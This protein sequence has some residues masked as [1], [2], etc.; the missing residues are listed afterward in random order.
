MRKIWDIFRT[1]AKYNFKHP[2]SFLLWIISKYLLLACTLVL[3]LLTSSYIDNLTYY[4][5]RDAFIRIVLLVLGAMLF[6][7]VTL[8]V[9]ECV[10]SP[11]KLKSGSLYI[12]DL[13]SRMQ[14]NS[15]KHL[16]SQNSAYFT[17]ILA[18]S[19]NSTMLFFYAMVFDMPKALVTLLVPIYVITTQEWR[20]SLALI[21]IVLLNFV[22]Y[23]LLQNPMYRANKRKMEKN[24]DYIASRNEQL[25]AAKFIK[26]NGLYQ[27]FASRLD[28]S[29]IGYVKAVKGER[30]VQALYSLS[31]YFVASGSKIAVYFFGGL[32]VLNGDLTV[33]T[34]LMLVEYV[35]M[36]L[37]SLEYFNELGS[38]YQQASVAYDKLAEIK[39][40]YA[41]KDG[42]RELANVNRVEFKNLC[43]DYGEK[44]IFKDFNL[45]LTKGKLYGLYGENGAGK[46]TLLNLLLGLYMGDYGGE[47][48]LDGIDIKDLN[49]T[50]CKQTLIGVTEQEPLLMK[51]TLYNNICLGREYD[52]DTIYQ[53]GKIIGLSSYFDKLPDG[54]D[55]EINDKSTN[56]SGGEKQKISILRQ[57]L[58]NPDVMIFD[59]PTSA[60]DVESVKLFMAYIEQIKHDKI[61]IMI[62]HDEAVQNAYDETISITKY[63]PEVVAG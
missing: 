63:V 34:V 28:R 59:E 39:N 42:N 43:F 55:T 14:K 52:R 37:E 54:L 60:L 36:L 13:I 20:V 62:S 4:L 38:V 16:S 24:A 11:L 45:S 23:M 35:G 6:Q 8:I 21:L 12:Q 61:I 47:I 10:F 26:S 30:R 57:M 29:I 32:S 7:L 49:L 15:M 53:Y 46:S 17:S 5:S 40:E 41:H 27:L 56:I 51:D 18:D 2:W 31:T 33:G 22:A 48:C 1:G 25:D 3:P 19:C 44:T 9:T 58:K 50:K